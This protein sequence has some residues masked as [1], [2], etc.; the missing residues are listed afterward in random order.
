MKPP[1]Q[2]EFNS[3]SKSILGRFTGLLNGK[4]KSSFKPRFILALILI[5]CYKPER[6]RYFLYFI[7][8]APSLNNKIFYPFEMDIFRNEV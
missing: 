8:K 5:I 1:N 2:Y 3:L 7:K 6:V 4:P